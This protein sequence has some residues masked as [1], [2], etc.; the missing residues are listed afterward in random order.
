MFDDSISTGSLSSTDYKFMGAA[1]A[2]NSVIFAPA[3][4]DVVGTFRIPPSPP[5]H[6]EPPLP[7][8]CQCSDS[9]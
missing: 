6:P 5:H 4:A 7:P 9:C 8:P 1:A 3:N 2:G